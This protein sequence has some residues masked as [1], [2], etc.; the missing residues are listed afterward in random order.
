MT[1]KQMKQPDLRGWLTFTGLDSETRRAEAATQAADF[2]RR[3]RP[4]RWKLARSADHGMQRC[5]TRPATDTEKFLLGMLGHT[6]PADL[7]TYLAWPSGN[8]RLRFWP[9]LEQEMENTK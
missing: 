2:T 6:V 4:G 1:I 9:A 7:T 3:L 5:I 8:I